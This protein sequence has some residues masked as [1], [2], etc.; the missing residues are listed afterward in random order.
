[1]IV[2]RGSWRPT[3]LPRLTKDVHT[4]TSRYQTRYN[5]IAWAAEDAEFWWD[6]EQGPGIY[7]PPTATMQ[8]TPEARTVDSYVE[9]FGTLG[10]EPCGLDGTFVRGWDK[11]ALYAKP[12]ILGPP[13]ATHAARQL[14]SGNG[15]ASLGMPKMLRIRT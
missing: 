4:I 11:I 3:D 8:F 9:A 15:L 1:M 10:Y 5:C 14:R 7:W 2:M 13:K 12:S 6:P